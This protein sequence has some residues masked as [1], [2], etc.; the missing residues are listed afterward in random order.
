MAL[1]PLVAAPPVEI[2]VQGADPLEVNEFIPALGHAQ[3]L[4][5]G[6]FTF[7]LG[8]IGGHRVAVSYTGEAL[9]NCTT[10]TVIGIEEFHPALIV[11]QG[12]SGAQV[13]YLGLHDIVVGRRTLDYGGFVSAPRAAGEGSLPLAWAP[14]PQRLRDPATGA[15]AAYPDGFPGDSAAIALAL[16]TRNPLGR[17]FAGVIGSAHEINL[18]L[19]RVEWS[20]RTFGMDVEEMESGYV[21]AVAHAYGIRYIAFRVVSDA[22][23]DGIR[24]DPLCRSRDVPLHLEFHPE[25]PALSR[26]TP[27]R[28]PRVLRPFVVL[29]APFAPAHGFAEQKFDLAV[30]A[31]QLIRRPSFQL[32]P[33]LGIDAQEKGLSLLGL[34]QLVIG[35]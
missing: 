21:A 12:T 15:L 10:A 3:K 5:I 7:W 33:E 25:S 35:V 26:S 6:P 28:P 24:F 34:H 31:P 14:V 30:H 16:R 23:Y 18:E 11:N 13:P 2:L 9:L 32:L 29:R 22:P 27:R 4:A 8:E 1:R 17:V 19:D 20:H